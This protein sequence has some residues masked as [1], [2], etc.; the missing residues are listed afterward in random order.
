MSQLQLELVKRKEIDRFDLTDQVLL[1]ELIVTLRL[2]GTIDVLIL[3][4]ADLVIIAKCAK[5]RVAL[6]LLCVFGHF[7]EH[8]IS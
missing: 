6:L 8:L 2:N 4:L 3:S 5:D 1:T 7:L